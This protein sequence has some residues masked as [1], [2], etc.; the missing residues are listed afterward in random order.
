MKISRLIGK[1]IRDVVFDGGHEM[2]VTF[3]DGTDLVIATLTGK[4][5]AEVHLDAVQT[6]H[7]AEVPT[8]RQLEYLFF[9][10]KY[11]RRYG[12]APAESDIEKHFLVSAPSVNRMMQM[13]ERRGFIMREPG[14]PR[15]TKIRIDLVPFG[16]G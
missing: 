13:L 2:V 16:V 4:L 9:I 5:T 11:I 8:K 10:A 15:S 14:V 3:S 6:S 1:Q 7:A 12:R